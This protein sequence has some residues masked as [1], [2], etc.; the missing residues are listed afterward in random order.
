[1]CWRT[2][3]SFLYGGTLIVSDDRRFKH[4][5]HEKG[6]WGWPIVLLRV[7][8]VYLLGVLRLHAPPK[9]TSGL[10]LPVSLTHLPASKKK[11]WGKLQRMVEPPLSASQRRPKEQNVINT[12]C[13]LYI[14]PSRHRRSWKDASYLCRD[15]HSCSGDVGLV[16]YLWGFWCIM[17]PVQKEISA[18]ITGTQSFVCIHGST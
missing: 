10:L 5:P 14:V 2:W 9:R 16:F 11:K 7:S 18:P 8:L 3:Q 13:F 6:I 17:T 4:W 15:R 12:L 1:M